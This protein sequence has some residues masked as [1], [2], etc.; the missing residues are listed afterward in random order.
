MKFPARKTVIALAAVLAMGIAL[1]TF[2]GKMDPD[3]RLER[4]TANLSL[5][6]EQVQQ[7]KPLM[8]K[9]WQEMEAFREARK[10]EREK[11]REQMK[12]MHDQH[13]D[14]LKGVLTAEQVSTLEE[15][16]EK[17]MERKGERRHHKGDKHCENGKG[18][19]TR[20]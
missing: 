20:D 15:Q 8:E 12:T 1:P 5:S 3:A 2:A 9:H 14:E 4:M 7:V 19:K 16:R 18:G 13:F 11:T 17:R 10:V 6:E